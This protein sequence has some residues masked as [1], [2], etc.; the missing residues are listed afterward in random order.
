MCG[1]VRGHMRTRVHIRVNKTK[2][3]VPLAIRRYK[4]A[5]TGFQPNAFAFYD[6][7]PPPSLLRSFF[8]CSY[9]APSK[10][11]ERIRVRQLFNGPRDLFQWRRDRILFP[12]RLP[13]RVSLCCRDKRTTMNLLNELLPNWLNDYSSHFGYGAS[14][15]YLFPQI[16]DVSRLFSFFTS[17]RR[18]PSNWSMANER[19]LWIHKAQL[20]L[21][22]PSSAQLP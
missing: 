21:F 7:F 12:F 6:F 1:L 20:M 19:F 5:W 22:N 14:W 11:R 15:P 13:P 2:L 10:R 8:S 4:L 3:Y 16:S 9:L 17:E 18:T